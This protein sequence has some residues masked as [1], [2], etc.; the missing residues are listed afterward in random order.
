MVVKGVMPPMRKASAVGLGTAWLDEELA[1][2]ML[3]LLADVEAGYG[4][5]VA[6]DASPDFAWLPFGIAQ[7]HL[8]SIGRAG[9]RCGIETGRRGE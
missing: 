4:A 2:A 3:A 6:H 7:L 8:G 1:F 5:V 9:I